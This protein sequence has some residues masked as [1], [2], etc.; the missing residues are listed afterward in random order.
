[1]T[2]STSILNNFDEYYNKALDVFSERGVNVDVTHRCLLQCPFCSRQS[3]LGKTMVQKSHS[4]GDLKHNHAFDLG[5]TFATLSLCGQ[6]SDPIYHTDFIKVFKEFLKS[7]CNRID[8]HTTGSHKKKDFWLNLYQLAINSDKKIKFVFGIDGIDEKSSIHRVNQNTDQALE[9][10]F[11]GAE[12]A[13]NNDNLEIVWQYIPFAYNENDLPSAI[14]LAKEKGI[15]FLMLK[16]GRFKEDDNLLE[17]PKNKNLFNTKQFA[18]R[19]EID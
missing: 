6:I 10:M 1:M 3:N 12:Y 17:P 11:L 8:V 2:S 16:S 14:E 18:E 19:V 9:A 15:K 4:Y 13:K 5:N 7:S